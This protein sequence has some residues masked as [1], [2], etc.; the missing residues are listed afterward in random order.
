MPLPDKC[1]TDKSTDSNPSPS[2]AGLSGGEL[3][4]CPDS[5]FAPLSATHQPLSGL[6][7]CW[8]YDIPLIEAHWLPYTIHSHIP[9]GSVTIT[10]EVGT[11]GATTFVLYEFIWI[12]RTCDCLVECSLMRAV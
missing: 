11:N 7:Q 8:A 4:R 10:I 5:R 1:E 2:A 9:T 12:R 6:C 3:L